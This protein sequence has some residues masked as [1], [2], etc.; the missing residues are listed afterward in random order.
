MEPLSLCQKERYLNQ[1]SPPEVGTLVHD[2]P[3]NPAP[4][5]P[6]CI[7]THFWCRQL[8]LLF[9]EITV[10]SSSKPLCNRE[11]QI[12]GVKANLRFC[13]QEKI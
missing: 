3:A 11:I 10:S 6:P 9:S 2:V 5:A 4:T 1:L 12:L 8:L 13:L 7:D